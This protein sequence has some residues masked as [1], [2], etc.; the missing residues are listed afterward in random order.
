MD[1]QQRSESPT[2][3]DHRRRNRGEKDSQPA[4]RYEV[5]RIVR[6]SQAS[7]PQSKER[8]GSN[9]T[10][11]CTTAQ[12]DSLDRP[13]QTQTLPDSPLSASLTHFPGAL[14][15][16]VHR[17]TR[18]TVCAFRSVQYMLE[19]G[20][21]ACHLPPV[22]NQNRPKSPTPPI[23]TNL[24]SHFTH[25]FLTLRC[26]LR[27]HSRSLPKRPLARPLCLAVPRFASPR[28]VVVPY[29]ALIASSA[30]TLRTDCRVLLPSTHHTTTS[31]LTTESPPSKPKPGTGLLLL[32]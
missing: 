28:L 21:P 18:C 14:P 25:S 23:P 20:V 22:P 6:T 2:L 1:H 17:R 16:W 10:S 32:R 26:H 5:V 24:A 29:L 9:G 30:Q 27:H 4:G 8:A 31:T 15:R 13:R 19:A 12:P 11:E 7:L 3:V